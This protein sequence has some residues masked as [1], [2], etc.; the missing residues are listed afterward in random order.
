MKYQNVVAWV[1]VKGHPRADV[2][3][4]VKTRTGYEVGGWVVAKSGCWSML[5]G[6]FTVNVSGPAQLYFE[7]KNLQADIWADSI[8]LQPFTLQEWK[9]HQRHNVEKVRKTGVKFNVLDQ[10]GRPVHNA[11]V[12]VTQKRRRFPLGSAINKY[13]LDNPAYQNWFLKRFKYTVFENELKWYSTEYS[14]GNTDYSISDKLVQFAKSHRIR[15]RGH[16][17]FWDVP[18]A[19]PYWV[20]GLAPYAFG[21]A[22]WKRIYSVMNRYKGQFIH[23]DVVNENMHGQFLESKLGSGA[24]YN[25]YKIANQI[26]GQRA[27]PFLNDY[28][29]IEQCYDPNASPWRYLQ[30]INS[31]RSSGYAGRF[32][33]GLEGHFT[34][35]NLAYIRSALDVLA[36]ARARI[37]VTE[38]DVAPGPNQAYFLDQILHELFSHPKV[39][40]IMMWTAINPSGCYQMCLTDFNFRNLPTG[41]VVDNFISQ[42]SHATDLPGTTD[43][44]GIYKTRLHHGQYEVK[45]D[46]PNGRSTSFQINVVPRRQYRGG[47]AYSIYI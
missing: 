1:Q 13:I 45:V 4:V 34:Y 15:I 30:D 6:G 2:A 20:N 37:W 11:T 26:D 16:N 36:A 9:S 12:R 42:L 33:I 38:L 25:F 32:G 28:N 29:T 31:L 35:A 7:S 40:G 24:S 10:W 19:Q 17:I 3:V 5:K 43:S 18:N 27:I 8:S 46:H 44:N 21:E 47:H 22:A 41:D 23:W 14:P 39:K